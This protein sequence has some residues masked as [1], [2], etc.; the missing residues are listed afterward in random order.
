M[1][2]KSSSNKSEFIKGIAMPSFSYAK[3]GPDPMKR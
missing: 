2:I 1:F 3:V